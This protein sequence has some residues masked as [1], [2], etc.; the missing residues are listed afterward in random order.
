MENAMQVIFQILI[1]VFSVIIHEVAHGYAALALGDRTAQYAGRLTL[2][3]VSHLDPFGSILLPGLL[4]F[5][6]M[7]I[8]GW[9]KP[10]P[11]NPYN[12]R[13]QKWGPAIVGAAGPA[14]N[15]LLALAF[16]LCIRF[17]PALQ[18][19]LS[20]TFL[21]NFLTIAST[22]AVLNLVLALFNLVPIPPL[23]GSKVLF[24]LLPYKW[25]EVETFLT[26]YGFI[27]LLTFIFFFSGFL[28]PI[29]L[30]LFRLITGSAPF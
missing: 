14:A 19:N 9:A 27:L 12:L 17:V 13:N 6:H 4:A 20:G 8:I 1:I 3:P 28:L 21:F 24:A 26:Q 10:V 11:Y 7:P 5:F 25:H 22:I 16:G 15:L 23:D 18:Y 29:V 2:N 30:L